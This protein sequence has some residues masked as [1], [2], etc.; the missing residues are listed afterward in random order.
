VVVGNLTP[1]VY[2]VK[3]NKGV[4]TYALRPKPASISMKCANP[5]CHKIPRASA[6][7]RSNSFV[8]TLQTRSFSGSKRGKVANFHQPRNTAASTL[9]QGTKL[10]GTG[11]TV[12]VEMQKEMTRTCRASAQRTLTSCGWASASKLCCRLGVPK[13]LDSLTQPPL[14]E[15]AVALGDCI[16]YQACRR[17]EKW[18]AQF[19]LSNMPSVRAHGPE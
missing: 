18:F 2:Q 12:A 5:Q 16:L 15:H 3:K 11:G 10:R 8:R 1:T 14:C 9:T 13:S 17:C 6:F 19:Y 4:Q 7:H